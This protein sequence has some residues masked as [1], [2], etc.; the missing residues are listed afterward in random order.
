MPDNNWQYRVTP[1]IYPDFW[2]SVE[3]YDTALETPKQRNLPN[4]V[5]S[6][7]SSYSN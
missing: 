5:A 1:F 2:K 7:H 6:A 3:K 4:Y